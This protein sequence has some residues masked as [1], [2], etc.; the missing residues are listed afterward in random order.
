[1]EHFLDQLFDQISRIKK[2]L[3]LGSHLDEFRKNSKITESNFIL[4]YVQERHLLRSNFLLRWVAF[5]VNYE[6]NNKKEEH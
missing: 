4:R 5:T 1:M 3:R 2:K 6:A